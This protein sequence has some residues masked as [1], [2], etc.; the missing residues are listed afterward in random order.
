MVS[1]NCIFSPDFRVLPKISGVLRVLGILA[2]GIHHKCVRVPLFLFSSGFSA[3]FW[4][5][6]YISQQH[7]TWRVLRER[8]WPWR[9]QCFSV[10]AITLVYNIGSIHPIHVKTIVVFNVLKEKILPLAPFGGCSCC[11]L[12]KHSS[13]STQFYYWYTLLSMYIVVLLWSNF[14]C[15]SLLSSKIKLTKRVRLCG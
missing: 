13:E 10:E 14:W 11:M 1:L 8:N 12:G 15:T 2:S 7:I 4:V 3:G 9:K 5:F 6:G